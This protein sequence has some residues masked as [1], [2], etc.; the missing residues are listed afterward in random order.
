MK[1]SR[2]RHRIQLQKYAEIQD[3]NTGTIKTWTTF[4]TV[5]AD[6]EPVKGYVT[7][8]TQQIDETV[9]HKITIRFYPAITSENWILMNSRRF[10]I[11]NVVNML[12]KNRFM[13]LLCEEVFH[14]SEPFLVSANAIG[15]ALVEDLP[16]E[17]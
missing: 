14:A 4:A 12:E 8:D 6:I 5:F 16:E 11:R 1:I 3:N 9:T 2:L 7:F 15:D 17:N 10:R 13:V